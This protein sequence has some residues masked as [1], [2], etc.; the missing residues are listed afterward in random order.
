MSDCLFCKIINREI[1]S[2]VVYEDEYVLAFEDIQ[3]AAP[4]HVLVIPKM[5]VENVE[6]LDEQSLPVMTNLFAAIQKVA[7]ITGIHKQGY[8]IVNNCGDFGGQTVYH[9]HL[10]VL[11][12]QKL[13]L[14]I[15]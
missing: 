4:V 10:H 3:P 11:G 2:K 1:P 15:V 6:A 5:H 12:G 8:R 9:L 14:K 13:P 7:Q